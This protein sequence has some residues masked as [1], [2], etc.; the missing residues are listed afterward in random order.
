MSD[1]YV[2]YMKRFLT[3]T[4]VVVLTGIEMKELQK[5][6]QMACTRLER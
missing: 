2:W 3:I 6:W 1:L 4:E 5:E